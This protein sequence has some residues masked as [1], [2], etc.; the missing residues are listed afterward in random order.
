MESIINFLWL[1][2]WVVWVVLELLLELVPELFD[3]ATL[4]VVVGVIR[5]YL[6]QFVVRIRPRNLRRTIDH[7]DP[8]HLGRWSSGLSSRRSFTV[9]PT[10]LLASISARE[11]AESVDSCKEEN[12][13]KLR[14]HVRAGL[15]VERILVLDLGNEQ[16]QK[17][18]FRQRAAGV[19]GRVGCARGGVGVRTRGR[20]GG[21]SRNVIRDSRGL[22]G[23]LT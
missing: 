11:E 1:V 2:Y 18:A 8:G 19:G 21:D 23:S 20:V 4:P 9:D 15:R 16:L 5:G 7:R 6:A 14:R 12:W 13:G 10:K 3:V 22:A 17:I